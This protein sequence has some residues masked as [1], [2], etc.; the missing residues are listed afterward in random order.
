[1]QRIAWIGLAAIVLRSFSVLLILPA[2]TRAQENTPAVRPML[3]PVIVSGHRAGGRVF[4][5][6]NSLPNIQYAVDNGVAMIEIDLRPTKDGKLVL[7]HDASA[8]RSVFFPDDT[9]N[10]RIVFEQLTLAEVGALRYSATAGGRLWNDLAIADADTVIERYKDKLNFHLDVKSTPAERIVR[11]IREH[12]IHDRVIVMSGNFDYIRQIKKACPTVIC[13]WP[14]NTLGRHQVDG[15]W[16]FY[17]MDRQLEEYRKA[18][19]AMRAAGA[20]MLCTKGLTVEKVALCHQYG[21]AVRP[22]AN[23]VQ[24]GDGAQYLRMGVDGILG[25][26]PLA[27]IKAVREVLGQDYIPTPNRTV[28]EI[29]S[30]RPG[31][32]KE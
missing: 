19:S 1:M 17:P 2:A 6:D 12:G 10:G 5:P 4:A 13:E 9:S 23:N 31:A 24:K 16:V 7:W 26:N 20:D 8:P 25:D 21:I 18:L 22:S 28:T 32:K 30:S 14:D 27:T 15:R 29:F 3:K 11:L